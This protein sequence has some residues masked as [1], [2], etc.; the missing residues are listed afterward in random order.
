MGVTHR[1]EELSGERRWMVR[2]EAGDVRNVHSLTHMALLL[3]EG[4]LGANP[5]VSAGD[6]GWVRL[7][8]IVDT[9]G[10]AATLEA[11]GH[12]GGRGH[13]PPNTASAA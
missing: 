1:D 12:L 3:L 13:E 7:S 8:R 5:E 9:Q 10:L 2:T 11:L 6:G 4:K